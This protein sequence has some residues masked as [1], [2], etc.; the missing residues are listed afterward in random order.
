MTRPKTLFGV[1]RR[2]WHLAQVRQATPLPTVSLSHRLNNGLS[3]QK[4]TLSSGLRHLNGHPKV[5]R[6]M[7]GLRGKTLILRNVKSHLRRISPL[8]LGIRLK[9]NSLMMSIISVVEPTPAL[10]VVRLGASFPSVPNLSLDVLRV[11]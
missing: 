5:V 2:H 10:T 11:C 6:Q 3:H 1:R 8:S 9:A 7:S 4:P